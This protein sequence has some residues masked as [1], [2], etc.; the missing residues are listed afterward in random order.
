MSSCDAKTEARSPLERAGLRS[1]SGLKDFARPAE[2][3][4]KHHKEKCEHIVGWTLKDSLG[5]AFVVCAGRE[6]PLANCEASQCCAQMST[7]A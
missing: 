6:C 7:E 5:S 2:S 1:T 4:P 3:K